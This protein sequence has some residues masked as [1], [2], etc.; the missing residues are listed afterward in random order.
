MS[1]KMGWPSAGR[2]RG[3]ASVSGERLFGMRTAVATDQDHPPN[4][5]RR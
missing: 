2:E 4:H 1:S 5:D 3:N